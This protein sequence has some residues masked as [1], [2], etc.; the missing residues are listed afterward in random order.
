MDTQL[1]HHPTVQRDMRELAAE[2]LP[3]QQ[4]DGKT[5]LVTGANGMLATYLVYFFH[6]LNRTCGVAVRTVAL[7]R[8]EGR[9]EALFGG[10]RMPG[11]TET[12]AADVCRPWPD[13]PCDWLFHLAGNASPHFIRTAP[14]DIL[15]A[16]LQGTF[17]ALEAA[18]RHHSRLCFVSTREVYGEVNDRLLLGEGDFGRLDPTDSRSCYPEAKRAAEA[19]LTAYG[20]QYGVHTVT[21]RLAHAYGPGMKLNDDG[22]VMADFMAAAVAGRPI[23]LHSTGDAERAFCYLTDAVAGLLRAALLAPAGAVYNLANEREPLPIREVARRVARVA[24]PEHP[25][26]V[27]FD[28]PDR[29]DAAYCAYRRVGLDTARIEAL[30]WQPRVSLD[31]GLKRTWESFRSAGSSTKTLP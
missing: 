27:Q 8:N 16:N 15:Q 14:A 3:W 22:R 5:I 28:I 2:D 11:V 21:L 17:H 19:L 13:T 9:L 18:R 20:R 4:F 6:Y 24:D 26:D 31:E 1:Y 10:L 12:L 29:P 7:S 23:V 30:G 25:L